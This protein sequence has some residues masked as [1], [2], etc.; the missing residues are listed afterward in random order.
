MKT[1]RKC[2]AVC[3]RGLTRSNLVLSLGDFGDALSIEKMMDLARDMA[4][5]NRQVF[6]ADSMVGVVLNSDKDA[7]DDYLK[8][9]NDFPKCSN[10]YVEAQ[11]DPVSPGRYNIAL[12]VHGFS[13]S[14]SHVCCI[15]AWGEDPSGF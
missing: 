14:T 10:K 7:I 15:R 4:Y 13:V 2:C 8:D 9:I 12:R 3:R 5:V 6:E 11:L 1:K